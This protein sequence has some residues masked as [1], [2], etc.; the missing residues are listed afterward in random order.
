MVVVVDEEEGEVML[1]IFWT[2]E[3]SDGR[4]DMVVAGWGACA[5]RWSTM[6]RGMCMCVCVCGR[7]M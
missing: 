5:R 2:R 6:R 1:V 7:L 4:N 3:S